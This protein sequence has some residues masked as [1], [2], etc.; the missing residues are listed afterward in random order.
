[1]EFGPTHIFYTDLR[2]CSDVIM[3][4]IMLTVFRRHL[5]GKTLR[6]PCYSDIA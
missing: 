2:C 4:H 3:F 1:V 6:N 5:V